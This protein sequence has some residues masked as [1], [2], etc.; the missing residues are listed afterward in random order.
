MARARRLSRGSGTD[1]RGI[2]QHIV[3]ILALFY[4]RVIDRP[5]EAMSANAF[6]TGGE[7]EHEVRS[8]FQLFEDYLCE[9]SEGHYDRRDTLF[10][11]RD[12]VG[13]AIQ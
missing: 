4:G 12:K 13:Q 6:A 8:T 9:A 7:V 2:S 10:R 1:K 5:E 11:S 3:L